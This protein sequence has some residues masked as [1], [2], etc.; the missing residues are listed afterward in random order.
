MHLCLIQILVSSLVVIYNL[1]I[2]IM[3]LCKILFVVITS[4]EHHT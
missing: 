2:I 3:V 1:V 4:L